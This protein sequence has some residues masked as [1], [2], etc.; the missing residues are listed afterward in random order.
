MT[1]TQLRLYRVTIV[2]GLLGIFV[3]YA[4]DRIGEIT[5]GMALLLGIFAYVFLPYVVR[6]K[7]RVIFRGKEADRYLLVSIEK[8]RNWS[9]WKRREMKPWHV[10]ASGLYVTN[11]GVHYSTFARAYSAFGDFADVAPSEDRGVHFALRDG[12]SFDCRFTS[13]EQRDGFVESLRARGI[14]IKTD[15]PA[16]LPKPAA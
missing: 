4:A 5:W 15:V 14:Q 3:L 6:H 16:T 13:K 12:R 7:E 2:F 10:F 8:K 1:H 9:S 11:D